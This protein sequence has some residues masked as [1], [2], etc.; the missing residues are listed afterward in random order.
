MAA[1]A[2]G[3]FPSRPNGLIWPTWMR[4]RS[5]LSA[6]LIPR[7]TCVAALRIHV[8]EVDDD[9]AGQVAQ[10]QLTGDFVGGFEVGAERRFL[11]V[12][13][14]GH[15]AGVDVDRDERF[16]RVDH[17]I[18]AGSNF[19]IGLYMAA[20]WASTWLRREQR[21]RRRIPPELYP[22]AWLGI[23]MRMNSCAALQPSSPSTSDLL[24]IV[25]IKVADGALD[26]VAFFV[27]Q[28]GRDRT[29]CVCSRMS[30]Q[31][32]TRYS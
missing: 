12:A 4:A 26:E 22:R 2:G 19:T 20:S 27:D 29:S 13:F 5:C 8:D 31:S 18:A 11:D 21:L 10:P 6:S 1:G 9:Q 14:A 17:Q 28:C 25:G 32:L 16:R 23:S 30:S 7:S 24:D 15:S 3:S